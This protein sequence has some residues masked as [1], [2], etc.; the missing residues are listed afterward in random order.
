MGDKRVQTNINIGQR[1]RVLCVEDN[2][3]TMQLLSLILEQ[4]GYEVLTSS[5][6]IRALQVL[7]RETVDLALLDYEM[8]QMNGGE[9]AAAAKCGGLATKVILFSG[10]A[11]IPQHD[12]A[13]V[14]RFVQKSEGVEVLLEVINSLLPIEPLVR[15]TQSGSHKKMNGSDE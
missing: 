1:C 13:F 5:D 14:D 2:V 8:P 9:L 11:R 4:Q 15:G 7:K 3:L 6:P 12:L 10:S